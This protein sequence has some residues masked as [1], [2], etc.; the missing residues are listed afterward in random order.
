M[1]RQK[2]AC[3]GLTTLRAE[4][5]TARA[6][7]P[8]RSRGKKPCERKPLSPGGGAFYF[9]IRTWGC[10]RKVP[11]FAIAVARSALGLFGADRK[12][13]NAGHWA[14]EGAHRGCRYARGLISSRPWPKQRVRGH[15]RLACSRL[16]GSAAVAVDDGRVAATLRRP[17]RL[18]AAI[19]LFGP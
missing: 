10:D 17:D 12:P 7:L 9:A 15:W 5:G 1:A 8:A 19:H 16:L 14:V 11:S 3:A 13:P 2:V 4:F 6:R 18:E